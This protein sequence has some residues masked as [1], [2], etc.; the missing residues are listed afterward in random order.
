MSKIIKIENLVIVL[1]LITLALTLGAIFQ[2]GFLI[3]WDNP[4]NAIRSW[5]F[6]YKVVAQGDIYSWD[7]TNYYGYP[8]ICWTTPFCHI[9]VA[10]IYFLFFKALSIFSVYKIVAVLAYILPG[11]GI[12]VL[13]RTLKFNR[14]AGLLGLLFSLL[15]YKHYVP[16]DGDIYQITWIGSP[17]QPISVGSL[18]LTLTFFIR[19]WELDKVNFGFLVISA[20]CA[21]FTILIHPISGYAQLVFL[22]LYFICFVVPKK[23]ELLKK[24]STYFQILFCFLIMCGLTAFWVFPYSKFYLKT[25]LFIRS[26]IMPYQIVSPMAK[27]FIGVHPLILILFIVGIFYLFRQRKDMAFLLVLWIGV[28]EL[29]YLDLKFHTNILKILP[30]SHALVGDG[31]WR[32]VPYLRSFIFMFSG[33]TLSGMFDINIKAKDKMLKHLWKAFLVCFL[34]AIVAVHLKTP[35]QVHTSESSSSFSEV[36]EVMDYIKNTV[37]QDTRVLIQDTAMRTTFRKEQLPPSHIFMLAPM[38]TGKSIICSGLNLAIIS[39]PLTFTDWDGEYF[40]FLFKV[41]V[42][43]TSRAVDYMRKLAIGYVVCYYPQIKETLK[44]STHFSEVFK[45][46]NFSIFALKEDIPSIIEVEGD[47]YFNIAEYQHNKIVIDLDEVEEDTKLFFK[48]TMFS[49]WRSFIDGREFWPKMYFPDHFPIKE[50]IRKN[51][52]SNFQNKIPFMFLDIE[53]GTKQVIFKYENG[54]REKT[55]IKITLITLLLVVIIGIWKIIP[56]SKCTKP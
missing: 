42:R 37:P 20:V 2:K 48:M 41:L 56:K 44:N 9:F 39:T 25:E 47:E 34:I 30:L 19:A 22:G 29:V 27:S 21:A 5:T 11:I 40:G 28:L 43:D 51:L 18:L 52:F 12:Y 7:P 14:L 32:F 55:G 26:P 35:V 23:K 50:G 45:G 17:F 49:S 53:K 3:S 46:E 6:I 24:S 33:I 31:T 8:T 13:L 4:I 15:V 36:M 1:I 38:L 16:W 10:L 54:P